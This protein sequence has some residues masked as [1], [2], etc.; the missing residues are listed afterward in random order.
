MFVVLDGG[1]SLPV[2]ATVGTDP[3]L[4]DESI[5]QR[6]WNEGKQ[7]R[8]LNA[9]THCLYSIGK[10]YDTPVHKSISKIARGMLGAK[11]PLLIVVRFIG[12]MELAGYL[13]LHE[14][15]MKGSKDKTERIII[16]T[17]KMLGLELGKKE[18][19][20]SAFKLP[21]VCG[22]DYLSQ[23]IVVRLG[24]VSKE[25]KRVAGITRNMSD[26]R[27]A[28]N[29][30]VLDLLEEFP[31]QK[32]TAQEHQFQYIVD[33]TM[34]TARK[35]K[36]QTFRFGYFLDSRSR[37]Y[38][39]TNC[40]ISPQGSD[41]EKALLIPCHSEPLTPSGVEALIGAAW[42]YSEIEW[43]MSVMIRHARS[44]KEFYLEWSQADKPYSYMACAKLLEM[45]DN[46]PEA[47][48]PAFA[49]L[50][51]RCSG[52]QHWS[53]VTRSRAITAHLGMEPDEHE[54]DIYEKVALDWE[55]SL[56]A[57]QKSYATRKAAKVPVMTWGY[58]ATRM[59]S[60]EHLD[61]LYGQKR[62]WCRKEKA[63]VVIEEGLERALAGK[64]G[65]DLYDQ[66]NET[67]EELKT[68]VAWV[69]DCATLI[70]KDGN[71]DIHWPTPDGFECKQRKLKGVPTR[72][73]VTL[74]NGSRF[75][76][77]IL[78]YSAQVPAHGKH[79]SAIA[80]NVI[81]SL[82]ATHLRMV[83]RQLAALGLPMIFIHDSFATH[84]NHRDTLYRI[85]VDTFAELYDR[86]WLQELHDYWLARYG[87]ELPGPPALGDWEPASVKV[88][89]NFFM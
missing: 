54:L 86:N 50:D 4:R 87:V 29:E 64:L 11:E 15:K 58:N 37:M 52:L 84:V 12:E 35:L 82:D 39:N 56:P 65:C 16:P 45:Y 20:D 80:P 57:S 74:S 53:A 33:K 23:A 47:P 76:V 59:T 13:T 21:A 63:F 34:A 22:K 32:I 27:F 43:D 62:K 6:R 9:Y 30:F 88:L 40:G 83:A 41:Y 89:P 51:G 5:T 72:F 31:P 25:N 24:V 17:E 70:S 18:A 61:S 44:P 55:G 49:P 26:E 60:M 69:S 14:Q 36:G 2:P 42:G 67:L 66:L 28:V 46:D 1:V 38:A 68:A 71:C 3:F 7:E 8:W 77:G 79:R 10:C 73:E 81:H 48:L 19:P 75:T 85:I 78:D